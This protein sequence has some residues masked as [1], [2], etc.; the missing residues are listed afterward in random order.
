[1]NLAK[2]LQSL[3]SESFLKVQNEGV[4]FEKD[5]EIYAKEINQNI[6]LTFVILKDLKMKKIYATIASFDSFESIGRKDPIQ[7]MFHININRKEDFHYFEKYV[8]IS[9]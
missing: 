9:V 6:F 4:K 7:M 5:A 3:K 2:L 8:N 1:M